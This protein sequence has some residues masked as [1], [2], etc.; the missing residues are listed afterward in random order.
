VYAGLPTAATWSTDANCR[1]AQTR[2]RN[3]RANWTVDITEP[4]AGNYNPVNCLIRTTGAKTTL[5]VAVDRSQGGSSLT[6]GALELMVHRRMLYDDRESAREGRG[7]GGGAA[8]DA[9]FAWAPVP[10]HL[11]PLTLNL[12]LGQTVESASR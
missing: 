3:F 2:V 6:D 8:G 9:A 10:S 5:A 12:T 4:V 7:G 1:E 11:H